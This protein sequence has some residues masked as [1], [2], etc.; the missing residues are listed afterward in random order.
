VNPLLTIVRK[1]LLEMRRTRRFLLR[2]FVAPSF[3]LLYSFTALGNLPHRSHGEVGALTASRLS[4][5]DIEA[6]EWFSR[7]KIFLLLMLPM[8]FSAALVMQTMVVEKTAKTL[9]PLLVT[10][11]KTYDLVLGKIL[12]ALVF[13]LLAGYLY[14]TIYVGVVCLMD[15]HSEMLR[16]MFSPRPLIEAFLVMPVSAFANASLAM[17][18]AVR[19]RDPKTGSLL[20]SLLTLPGI[21]LYGTQ[22]ALLEFLNQYI[23]LVCVGAVLLLAGA[24]VFF[25]T[26]AFQREKVFERWD[27]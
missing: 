1:E 24:G 23:L 3:V 17:I 16:F 11:V 6:A 25:A 18:V 20:S 5:G 21:V 4:S 26:E 10:P 15:R 13:P 12:A 9:E 8:L 22:I 7:S 14:L 27:S 19:S 2:F